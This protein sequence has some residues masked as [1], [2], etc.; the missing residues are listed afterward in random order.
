MRLSI[1]L[2]SAALFALSACA[3]KDV[4]PINSHESD[5]QSKRTDYIADHGNDGSTVVA[6]AFS[7]GGTRSAA[8]AYG[9]LQAL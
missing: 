2:I 9:V 1:S 5:I 7:G 3:S 6:L 4:G 8:F